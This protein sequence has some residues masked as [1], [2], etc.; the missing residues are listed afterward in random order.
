M[1]EDSKKKYSANLEER[2]EWYREHA[3]EERARSRAYG[4]SHREQKREGVKKCYYAKQDYYLEKRR[5]YVEENHEKVILQKRLYR[6]KQRAKKEVA[7][8]EGLTPTQEK[9]MYD[10]IV[11]KLCRER[12]VPVPEL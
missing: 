2:R 1:S 11:K 9:Q 8:T 6:I 5:Q 3:E 12:G 7:E 10:K 4:A